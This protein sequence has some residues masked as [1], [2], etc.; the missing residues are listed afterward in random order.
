MQL[1]YS[2]TLSDASRMMTGTKI[3]VDGEREGGRDQYKL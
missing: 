1:V 2:M 3:G